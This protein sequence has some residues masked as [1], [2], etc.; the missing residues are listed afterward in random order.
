MRNFLA[1]LR[2]LIVIRLA[3]MGFFQLLGLGFVMAF[4]FEVG[5]KHLTPEMDAS[6]T[7][8]ACVGLLVLYV[9]LV[10]LFE[11]RWPREL[12]LKPGV[13]WLGLGCAIGFG[14]FCLVLG[15][16]IT[17]GAARLGGLHL[18]SAVGDAL[19]MAVVA[20]VGEE[21][22]FRG[23]VFRLLENG[24]GT[25]VALVASSALF[26][27]LHAADPGATTLSTV[28]IAL[29][30]GTMFALAYVWSRSLWLPIGLHLAWNF[31]EGGVFG[32]AVS[33]QSS[34]GLFAVEMSKT[35]SPLLTGGTFGPEG[36]VVCVV[37]CVLAAA[38]FLGLAIS[39]G[40]WRKLSFHLIEW[41]TP[42]VLFGGVQAAT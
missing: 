4:H 34:Q 36:S 40:R 16:L 24:F 27:V 15:V 20:A 5:R 32:A 12:A 28:E 23:V 17:S 21:L 26:G 31:T 25:A 42:G 22:L 6:G 2:G 18:S 11:W 39:N 38:V 30:A 37:V 41:K 33:G 19:V 9:L 35:A 13:G 29:E 8:A 14:L 7:L 3:V 10:R 1:G